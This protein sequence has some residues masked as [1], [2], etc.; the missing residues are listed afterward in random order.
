MCTKHTPGQWEVRY[1]RR[2]VA[3]CVARVG[4][5]PHV[6][7]GFHADRAQDAITDSC[8]N[9]NAA[10]IAA[11][12]DLLAALG[13]LLRIMDNNHHLTVARICSGAEAQ[14]AR[15]AIA[16]AKEKDQCASQESSSK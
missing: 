6:T 13:G 11:A 4:Y 8:Q 5:M 10:L 16:K 15:E 7:I 14:D 3:T 2:G 12:P 1:D 9:A